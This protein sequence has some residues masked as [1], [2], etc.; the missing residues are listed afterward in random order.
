[1]SVDGPK[2]FVSIILSGRHKKYLFLCRLL[3][4]ADIKNRVYFFV[5]DLLTS[6]HKK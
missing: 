4:T 2:F 3:K 5:S 1:M 6:R